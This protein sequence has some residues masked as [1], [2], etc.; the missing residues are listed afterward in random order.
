MANARPLNTIV[1]TINT[2]TRSTYEQWCFKCK[3]ELGKTLYDIVTG[4][5]DPPDDDDD[6]AT[7]AQWEIANREAMRILIPSIVE[8]EFQLIRNCE[9]AAEMWSVLKSNFEDVSMLR[10][11]N[12]FEQ[13]ISLRYLADK[14][15]H[16]H[17]NA[18]NKLYQEIKTYKQ[19]KDLSD[20]IWVTRF[21]RSL[22][23][24]YAT[25]ARSYD[26]EIEKTKLFDVYDS[27]H[28]EF[29]NRTSPSP[30]TAT[31]RDSANPSANFASSNTASGLK[32]NK[33]GNNKNKGKGAPTSM[34]AA[35]ITSESTDGCSYCHRMNHTAENCYALKMKEFYEQHNPPL[36][37]KKFSKSGPSGNVAT[38]ESGSAIL[39]PNSLTSGSESDVWVIDSGATHCMVPLDR[40]CFTEYT[41][42]V[43]GTPLIKGINGDTTIHGIGNLKLTS[44]GGELTLCGV[45][46]APGLPH[47]ILSLGV[48]M[49]DDVEITFRKPYCILEK[50]GFYIK[51]KFT[52]SLGHS[53]KLFRFSASFPVASAESNAA[54]MQIPTTQKFSPELTE[55]QISL[56]HARI[57]HVAV[58]GFPK[59]NKTA[60][61]PLSL[62]DAI[63]QYDVDSISDIHPIACGP[64]LQ[65]KQTRLPL[66]SVPKRSILSLEVIHTDTCNVPMPSIKGYK[67]FVTFT[68]EATR[69]S[70]IYY[71]LDKKPATV[72]GLFLKFK[73]DVELHFSKQRI[74]DQK[75]PDGRRARISIYLAQFE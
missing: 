65:G 18:F 48:L 39:D 73:A 51:S 75:Y 54:S 62:Q 42:D 50:D 29:N 11:C 20:A 23:P 58:S 41:T 32:K 10:Q 3:I 36:G 19:F 30:V 25:F 34:P 71:L 1:S 63:V 69:M 68:D 7:H 43:P 72:L 24:E 21:L 55:N 37:K 28:S 59:I 15:I 4:Q 40:S 14:T 16:D 22:P 67:D 2:L 5:T 33:K 12:T 57:G 9:T 61:I 26:K 31:S 45:L 47:C 52:A 46:H 44:P 49:M 27:L 60:I 74:Q 56:W 64:C 17:I 13:L 66:P 6:A 70:F 8:P 35:S 38:Y 53:S